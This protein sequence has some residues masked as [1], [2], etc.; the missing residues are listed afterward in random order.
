MAKTA[1]FWL[2]SGFHLL[3]RNTDGKLSVTDDFLRAYFARPEMRPPEDSCAAEQAL[4]AA[5]TAEPRTAIDEQRLASLADA[6]ARDNYRHVL[7]LRDLL[8][9]HG[10][11]EACY[12]ALFSGDGVAVPPLF[13]DQ[14]AH[15]VLRNILDGC[16]D[17]LRLRAAEIFFRSQ[18]VTLIEGAILLADE[19]TVEM[20][21]QTSGFGNIGRLLA[22]SGTP[23]RAVDL[24]VLNDANADIYWQ[25][26]DRY[27]TVLDATFG[28]AGLAALSGVMVDWVR[29]FRG[30][31][32]TIE[33]V[34]MIRD[35][36]WVW[37]LGLDTESS[38]I[39]N[40]LYAGTEIDEPRMTRLLSLFR[41][42]FKDPAAMRLD[43]AGR[44]IYLGM[45]MTEAGVLRLKPQNLLVNLPLAETA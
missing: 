27:D 41:L 45:A 33:P 4:H 43:I 13:I 39:L 44:P 7:R 42:E 16:T 17:P 35:D 22:Q 12:L 32:V 10:T 2:S 11:V 30:V 38:A 9:A 6:D 19:E 40:D 36:H 1:D 37:H 14:L 34:G 28:R 26:D 23:A 25:R 31:D 20:Y 29:H 24:D 15:A 21:A 5:L 3:R 18:K 8:V